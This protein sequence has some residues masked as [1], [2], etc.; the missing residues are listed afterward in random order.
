MSDGLLLIVALTNLVLLVWFIFTMNRLRANTQELVDIAREF[1]L[2][3]A[4]RAHDPAAPPSD[5]HEGMTGVELV[6]A[7]EAAGGR[8]RLLN[9]VMGVEA[10]LDNPAAVSAHA[11]RLLKSK[12]QAVVRVLRGRR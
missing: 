9:D 2:S 8:L 11:A 5:F 10:V 6:A 1:A 4:R 12:N 7:V 3:A